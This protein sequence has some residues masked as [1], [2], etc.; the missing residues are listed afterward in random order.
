MLPPLREPLWVETEATGD[1]REP[2]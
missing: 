1:E 2:W